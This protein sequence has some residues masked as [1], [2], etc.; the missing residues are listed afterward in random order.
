LRKLFKQSYLL[1]EMIRTITNPPVTIKYPFGKLSLPSGFRGKVVMD[2]ELC[3]GCGQ[4][5]RDCPCFALSMERQKKN[6]FQI[7]YSPSNCAF[8]G[9]CELSCKYG[10]IRLIN[11]FVPAV[12][13]TELLTEELVHK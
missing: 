7:F 6:S 13:D 10:A 12:S 2:S 5:V 9:Q 3:I 1:L 11:Q 4:C 8:C